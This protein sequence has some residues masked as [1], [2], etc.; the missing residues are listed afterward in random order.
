MKKILRLLL[1]VVLVTAV[2]SAALVTTAEAK[3]TYVSSTYTNPK[4]GQTSAGVKALQQRLVKA[5]VLESKYV[6]SYF[7]PVTEKAVKKFQKKYKY[8]QTGKVN[9]KTWKKLVS[10]TGK[11]KASST[12]AKKKSST[13]YPKKGQ[14]SAKVTEL[15][16]R[17]VKAKVLSSKYVTGTFGDITASAVKKFQ[18]KYGYKQTGKV[19]SLTWNKLVSKTGKI[20]APKVKGIDSRCKVSGR[21]L[22]I[23]KRTDKLHYL[24]N[25]KVIKTMDAR[26]GCA[27]TRTREGKFSVLWK[28]R[29]HVST[30]YDS[31]MPYAMFF[32]G[33]QAVHYSSD[34]AARGYAGCSHGCVNIRDKAGIAWLFDQMRNGDR[35]VVYRS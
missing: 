17:L 31:P 22:C 2:S 4:K 28:S 33:G 25:G 19:N 5:K 23:D 16:Q 12:P 8:K 34:F 27:A 13:S 3:T 32:S 18:K 30:L 7:G 21:A 15:Q 11:I 14:S 10:K 9:S 29:H 26:F 20:S 1:A 6:T 35:V 24:K